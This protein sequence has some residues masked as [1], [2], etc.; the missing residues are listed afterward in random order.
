V[1]NINQVQIFLGQYWP[2]EKLE[3]LNPN[4]DHLARA[5]LY[6]YKTLHGYVRKPYLPG[7]SAVAAVALRVRARVPESRVYVED[8]FDMVL[9]NPHTRHLELVEYQTKPIRHVNPLH[10]PA[11]VL[12]KQFLCRRLKTRWPFETLALTTIKIG[13]QAMQ[14]HKVLLDESVFALNWHCVVKDLQL[15]KERVEAEPHKPG[16]DCKYCDALERNMVRE[17]SDDGSEDEG[18]DRMRLCMSA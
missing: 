17:K 5:F 8:T 9:W 16:D 15:M 6:S 12:I 2:L 1:T 3:R 11:S 7:A 14:R 4:K 10:P 13:P 18:D